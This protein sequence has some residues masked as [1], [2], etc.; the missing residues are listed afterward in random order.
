M[1]VRV[2][3]VGGYGT[4][5][6][7]LARLLAADRRFCIIIAGRSLDQAAAFCST[8][9]DGAERLPLA[10]DRDG[11]IEAGLDEARPDLVIDAAGPFQLYGDDPY[12]LARACIERG[13]SYADLADSADF[14]SGIAELDIAA[15]AAGVFLLSG[16]STFPA[17]SGAVVRELSR[18]FEEVTAVRA[19]VMP[20]PW[21]G[22]GLSVVR[23][24]ASY[25]GKPLAVRRCGKIAKR[26]ALIDSVR[27]TVAVPG[28][29]PLRNTRFSLAETPDLRLLMAAGDVW[30]GAGPQPEMLHDALR[31]LAWLVRLRIVGSLAPLARL[32]HR[33]TEVFRWGERRGGMFL[34]VDGRRDGRPVSR[35]W[36]LSADGDRGPFVPSIGAAAVARSVALGRLPR[37]G[38]RAAGG[39]LHL[40]DYAPDF[41]ALGIAT[42]RWEAVPHDTPLYQRALGEA[43]LRLPAPLR[44]MHAG[45]E[46]RVVHGQAKVERGGGLLAWTVAAVMG[47]PK[48]GDAVPVEVRFTRR[49]QGEVWRRTFAGRSFSSTQELGRGRSE[50]LLVERFGPVAVGMAVVVEQERLR[51]SIRRATLFGVPLPP[52]LRPSC[53]DTFE[54]ASDGRF[55]FHV[56]LHA[57]LAGLVVRYRGWLGTSAVTDDQRSL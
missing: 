22:V 31:G 8:L 25:A 29:I 33:A 47:L 54:H 51:L 43:W 23:A 4:F 28:E 53:G 42:G 17:L 39:E 19:G 1:T 41:A 48:A 21:A 15:R 13:S 40:T 37:P 44:A 5:G 7:R 2:L 12:R 35:A 49:G 55:N 57:P 36:H 10:F 16:L 9:P 24:V 32:L 3:L 26:Y 14:V 11:D 30:T 45:G 20:S 50:R 46:E 56:E 38:A 18:D 34:E 52:W 27:R 6:G